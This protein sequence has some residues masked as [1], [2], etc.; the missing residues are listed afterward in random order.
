MFFPKE[1]DSLRSVLLTVDELQSVRQKLTAEMSDNS[2]M[3]KSLVLRAEDSRIMDDMCVQPRG[4]ARHLSATSL[5]PPPPYTH[6]H[7]HTK[8]RECASLLCSSTRSTAI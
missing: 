5:T 2:G 7:T 6:K 8:G 3:I 4:K 1:A